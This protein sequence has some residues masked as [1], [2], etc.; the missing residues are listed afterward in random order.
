MTRPSRLDQLTSRAFM[1]LVSIVLTLSVGFLRDLNMS[2]GEL[3]VKMA[4]II[5][6]TT[7]Q[8]AI[9]AQFDSRIARMEELF[10][11]MG[12]RSRKE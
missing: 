1:A 2:V 8:Q 10:R 7:Q 4:V 11:Q 9:N 3:N 5:E 12:L 6:K